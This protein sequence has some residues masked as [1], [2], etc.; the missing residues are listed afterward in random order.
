MELDLTLKIEEDKKLHEYLL[1][2][3]YWYRLLNRDRKEYDNLLKEYK[4]FNREKS[5]N[6]I[7]E[8]IE[9]AELISNIIKFVE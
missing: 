8:T 1:T 5:M 7:N 3:S 6:K 2:H 9:N 4:K